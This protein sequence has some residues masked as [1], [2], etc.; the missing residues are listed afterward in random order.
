MILE[1]HQVNKFQLIHLEILNLHTWKASFK[2]KLPTQNNETENFWQR[3][4]IENDLYD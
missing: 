3:K 4:N 2:L 1:N